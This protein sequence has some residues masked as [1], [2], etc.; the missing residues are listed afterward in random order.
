MGL[1]HSEMHVS[2]VFIV[3]K[4]RGPMGMPSKGNRQSANNDVG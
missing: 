1:N 2:V 4:I 3:V